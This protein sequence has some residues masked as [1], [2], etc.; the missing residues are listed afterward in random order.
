MALNSSAPWHR[1]SFDR[2]IQERLPKLL[3][4]RLPLAG[5]HAESTGDRTCSIKVLLNGKSGEIEL[6][7]P[8]LP[9][10]DRDGVFLVEGSYRVVVPFPTQRELDAAEIR[11]VGE[12]LY[13][14]FEANLGEAPDN[15]PWDAALA[16]AWLPLDA[17]MREFHAT[18]STSHYL[19]TT[20]WLD[21]HVHLRRLSLIP[22]EPHPLGA[23]DVILPGQMGRVCP[24]CTPE[25]PNV[26]RILEIAQGAEVRDGKLI[27]V[28]DRPE[29]SLGL[30]ASM[31][32]FLEHNDAN[33]MLMG[34]N[35]MRQWMAPPDPS[36]PAQST[37]WLRKWLQAGRP[38][39]PEPA[40]VQTGNEP[41]APNFWGG[42][43]LLTAYILWDGD[44]F[45]D[46]IVISESC[47]KR[48]NYPHPVEPGDKLSNRHGSKGV[49]SRILPDEEM[50]HLADG[51]PVE[52][53]FS[54]CSLPSRMN[55]G[56]VREAVMGRLAV[57]EGKPAIVPPF[58]APGKAEVRERL[59]AAGLPEDGMETLTVQGK[60]L[61]HPGTVGWVYWG[62]TVHI[63]LDKIHASVDKDAPCQHQGETGYLQLCDIEAFETI[64]GMFNTCAAE[65]DDADT[66]AA[67]VAEGPVAQA[68]P[69][70]PR[71]A[72][73]AVRLAASGIRVDLRG[74]ALT[75]Q[76]APPEGEAL[77]LVRPVPHPW[78]GQQE[79]VEVGTFEDLPEYGALV[80]A[81]VRLERMLHSDVPKPLAEK[82]FAQLSARVRAY[83]D[84]LLDPGCLQFEADVLFSGR[85]V[86]VPDADLAIDQVGLAEE[87]A[88]TLFGPLVSRELGGGEEV[89][90]RSKR[91]TRAL[92]EMM[93]RSWVVLYRPRV[94]MPPVPFIAFHPVR[95][96]DR[97]MR[98]HPLACELMN[99][100][101]DGDQVGVFL[102]IT[103]AAQQEAGERL[104]IAGHLGHNPEFIRSVCP[105]R[106]ALYGLARLSL[107]PKGG[108]EIEKLAGTTV[109]DGFIK[110]RALGDALQ[111]V[112]ERDGVQEALEASERLMRRGFEVAKE[113][114]A[115]MN[116]FLDIDL[117]FPPKP[118]DDAP[119]QWMA[120]YEE[121]SGWIDSQQDF[122]ED[123]LGPLWLMNK[124]GS[125][126]S[127]DQLSRYITGGGIRV[128]V[129]GK[130]VPIRHAWQEGLSPEE[131]F[132]GVVG[133]R[134][135][136][137][138]VVVEMLEAD[139]EVRE[140]YVPAGYNV[141]TRAR[142]TVQPGVVFA[143]AAANGEAD[144]L[145]DVYSR[146]FVGLTGA[147][148]AGTWP[149]GIFYSG[150][151]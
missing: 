86:I 88:W 102:P 90:K 28:D 54:L 119:E 144:P 125:R 65:R 108:Q 80:E 41:D 37:G 45:E 98:I 104:S 47:A 60:K 70:S 140:K 133:A 32:P 26:G 148:R 20:N 16:K 124:S 48:L 81:N 130:F 14:F 17:W 139:G 23:E 58:Q 129:R 79:L 94:L 12:Q 66:L 76:F 30:N 25:G 128:D 77:K 15:L 122:T 141:L 105:G 6:V 57:A 93:A 11:C 149:G 38:P 67:R 83:L 29:S 43:N 64:R 115:S 63:A 131:V 62:R 36:A 150:R 114:G 91:A 52:L 5:Y 71:F 117:D 69:P 113:S 145:T 138:R 10:P 27:V 136:L 4:D 50:P 127:I 95:C 40:L 44:A 3:A 134:R 34:A 73:L 132:A 121:A 143:R 42:Y 13:D 78:L 137:A 74:E 61:Q 97:V 51:Q 135:G 120:Y 39:K 84:T 21:T 56:Q 82:A 59:A 110:R 55:F 49:V 89:R 146:L 96:P 100:D 107:S 92:D 103:D 24:F 31:I 9:Q 85:A 35:M 142:R 7:Y 112:L 68:G 126:G 101:F 116:T 46:A 33:R 111:Q 75:F 72:D 19:Q 1:A 123:A 106:E 147:S 151:S 87:I 118:E 8:D 109:G 99:V 53:I 22:I 2:F 18:N